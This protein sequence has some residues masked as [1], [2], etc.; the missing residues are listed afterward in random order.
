MGT[1][2]EIAVVVA[3]FLAAASAAQCGWVAYRTY[4]RQR[5]F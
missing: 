5:L 2:L 3:A 4:W 1:T